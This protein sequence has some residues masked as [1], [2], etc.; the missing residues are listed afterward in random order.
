MKWLVADLLTKQGLKV[1][2]YYMTGINVKQSK[3]LQVT[4]LQSF[5]ELGKLAVNEMLNAI[6][7][8]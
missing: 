1:V 7:N 5:N 8:K 6:Q 3:L 2:N 4:V